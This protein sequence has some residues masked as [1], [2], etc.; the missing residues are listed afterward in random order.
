MFGSLVA[1]RQFRLFLLPVLSFPNDTIQLNNHVYYVKQALAGQTVI[2][3][4]D[5]ITCELLISHH[6][7]LIKQVSLQ[8]LMTL[9]ISSPTVFGF[10]VLHRT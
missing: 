9:P 1:V 4:V 10:G 2:V 8:G 5:A 7:T 3:K 6:F